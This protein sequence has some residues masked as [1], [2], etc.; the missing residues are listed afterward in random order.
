[1]F[2]RIGGTIIEFDGQSFPLGRK[3]SVNYFICERVS[4]R[5]PLIIWDR[6]ISGAL[7]SLMSL[8]GR[9][10]GFRVVVLLRIALPVHAPQVVAKGFCFVPSEGTS[11]RVGI[12]LCHSLI[13]TQCPFVI[14]PPFVLRGLGS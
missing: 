3:W 11:P 4:L 10:L 8:E 9:R 5:V 12:S 6:I 1:M 2:V 13:V 7:V 14:S